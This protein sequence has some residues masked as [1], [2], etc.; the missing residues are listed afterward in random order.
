[1]Y[2]QAHA[3][4]SLT[5]PAMMLKQDAEVDMQEFQG[6]L[7]NFY[8]LQQEAI[9]QFVRQVLTGGGNER[10]ARKLNF[11]I[12]DDVFSTYQN[13]A[14]FQIQ[15]QGASGQSFGFLQSHAVP[16]GVIS[17]V[18]I[19]PLYQIWANSMSNPPSYNLVGYQS[20]N[21]WTY[22]F[23][24]DAAQSTTGIAY[25]DLVFGIAGSTS[26]RL[27]SETG[28]Y[29]IGPPIQFQ[30]NLSKDMMY[31]WS[32]AS[33]MTI[34]GGNVPI[35]QNTTAGVLSM[36][37]VPTI[38]GPPDASGSAGGMYF[39]PA[40]L[41]NFTLSGK[42]D[43][44]LNLP[45]GSSQDEVAI[46]QGPD[47][48]WPNST[49]F[50]F[51]NRPVGIGNQAK[52][53]ENV[54]PFGPNGSSGSGLNTQLVSLDLNVDGPGNGF[55]LASSICWLSPSSTL[56]Y[57]PFVNG[58]VS[59]NAS[60]NV[61]YT[62]PAVSPW[63]Q[64]KFKLHCQFQAKT[65][66]LSTIPQLFS[67]MGGS[68][69]TIQVLTYWVQAAL[70]ASAAT[71]YLYLIST[72]EAKPV[73]CISSMSTVSYSGNT[74][75]ISAIAPAFNYMVSPSGGALPVTVSVAGQVGLTAA[76]SIVPAQTTYNVNSGEFTVEFDT[77]RPDGYQFLGT[78]VQLIAASTATG[79]TSAENYVQLVVNSI[80]VILP[81]YFTP[82]YYGPYKVAV[83]QQ[84]PTGSTI[85]VNGEIY[86]AASPTENIA[87]YTKNQMPSDSGDLIC[88]P[89]AFKNVLRQLY[90]DPSMLIFRR[91]ADKDAL[92]QMQY[93]FMELQTL[94]GL[95][96]ILKT[97]PQL[98][99]HVGNFDA[100]AAG[101]WDT[102]KGWGSALGR[103]LK[104]LSGYAQTASDIGEGLGHVAKGMGSISQA[105]NFDDEP[106][107]TKQRQEGGGGMGRRGGPPMSIDADAACYMPRG[108]YMRRQ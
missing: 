24:G 103:G 4:I 78:Y 50:S 97:S 60:T 38:A 26:S 34:S 36:G 73:G 75:I 81:N 6:I 76:T 105:L 2:K 93:A 86:Y 53:Y 88:A 20:N 94:A 31:G 15:Q 13:F 91:M 74:N 43:T 41:Q 11:P 80:D 19:P 55:S 77:D 63:D 107:R 79:I 71:P 101:F 35:A 66:S 9:L 25:T 108:R 69:A 82:G 28:Q 23:P 32:M 18:F 48:W 62:M 7:Q 45:M 3:A 67:A 33:K 64:P 95:W 37:I 56:Y 17:I 39:Q 16:L 85:N 83:L 61:S 65:S 47:G 70:P 29:V 22:V 72:S 89:V 44:A 100:G 96:G 90:D 54:F 99:R 58:Q 106:P 1:M 84:V 102:M 14:T 21:Q 40:S 49:A 8:R 46:I 12:N 27:S 52:L 87:S 30:P 92:K 59:Q 10:S 57:R 98:Q 68:I 42:K 51:D 104:R 5:S